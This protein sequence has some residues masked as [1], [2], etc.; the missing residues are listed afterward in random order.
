MSRLKWTCVLT[1]LLLVARG[2]NA[3]DREGSP[4]EPFGPAPVDE[5][6]SAG[7]GYALGGEGSDVL[8]PGVSQLSLHNVF[9]NYFYLENR[10]DFTIS[11]R[12]EEHTLAL[13]YQRGVRVRTWPRFEL[14][15]QLQVHESD[16]G[17][18]NGFITGFEDFVHAP[19]R[20]NLPE[21]PPPG[22]SIVQN[23]RVVYQAPINGAGVGDLSLVV[24]APLRDRDARS[25]ATQVA[26]RVAVNVRGAS[27]FTAGNFVASG[28]S[29]GRKMTERIALHGDVRVSVPLDHMGVWHLPLKREVVAYSWG[30]E[31]R[32]ANHTSFDVQVDNSTSP[33]H[34]TGSIGLDANYGNIDLAVSHRFTASGHHVIAQAYAQEN[35][36]MPFK[37]RWNMDPDLTIG[38]KFTIR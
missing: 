7:R 21:P 33:Y 15:A 11:Q 6:G 16:A 12:F 13:D 19:L 27:M 5:A 29:I 2:A 31:F 8:K 26:L 37:V 20:R 4:W 1:V 28:L 17:I 35:M 3:Q 18:L 14:S 24:K 23:G 10:G 9:A 25:R 32:V 30:S 22:M 34:T 38:L 36:N